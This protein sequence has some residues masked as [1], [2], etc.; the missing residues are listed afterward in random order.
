M[1]SYRIAL[2]TFGSF[3]DLHPYMAI[4]RELK[5]EGH[6]VIIATVAMYKDK[7]EAAGFEFRLLRTALVERPD[8]ELMQKVLDLR[9]GAEFIVR[10]LMM[11]A[12]ATAYADARVAFEGVS[13]VVLHPMVFAA[14]LA[15]EALGIPWV[16]T[17]LAPMGFFSP[18]D[19]PTL[20]IAPFL[21]HLR[22]LGPRFF[23]PLLKVPKKSV[24]SWTEPYQHMRSELGLAAVRRLA[25]EAADCG[26]LSA[27]LAAGIRLVKGAKRLVVPVGNWLTAEQGKRLLLM[28]DGTSLRDKRDY[29]TLAI[30]L[31][32]GLRRAELTALRVEDIQQREEHWVIADLVGKGGHVRTI[33]VPDWVKAGIDVWMGAAGIV[34]GTLFRSINKVG[35]IWGSGFSPKVIWGVVKQKAKDCEIPCLAPHDLRRTCARLCH[36]AG[37]ELEQI[38]FLLGHVS[39]QTTERYLGCKQRFRNAVNDRIGL[40]PDPLESS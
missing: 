10:K 17:Q 6:H 29:A 20:P 7:V 15:A 28:A 8:Q 26:L 35:R 22:F 38:Q 34:T 12:L 31:G 24:G 18:Y 4:G 27:D 16:F 40:E 2:A 14:R 19:P 36:Q 11:P 5:S 3:G 39:V 30:L 23:G 13:L 21:G 1:P 32:C 25:Y 9:N 33:P 37:G